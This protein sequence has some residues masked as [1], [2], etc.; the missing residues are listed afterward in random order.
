MIAAGTAGLGVL[1][2]F[3][4]WERVTSH[5]MLNLRFFRNRSFSAAVSSVWLVMFGLYGALF[6][7]TQYL[8]F[9][10]GYTPLQT[11]LRVLPAAAAVALV[12]PVSAVS[13]RLIGAKFTTAIG[14][15]IVTAGLWQ[16][17]GVSVTSTYADSVAGLA[18][19]G[20]G[21]G[22]TIPCTTAA[23]MGSVPR[24]DTGVGSA[25]N[26]TFMQ[27]GGALGVAVIGS[28]LATRY[29]GRMTGLLAP[30]HLP[31]GITSIIL[32]SVGGA[33]GAADRVG[34]TAGRLLA[35]AAQTSFISGMDLGLMTG[36]AVGLAGCLV[37]LVAMPSRPGR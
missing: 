15:L 33:L 1:A 34:G 35:H 11:G 2:G 22:L 24:G 7:L 6:V 28:L 31:H 26:G 5:P 36:A 9:L 13:V 17:S 3:A 32:G 14:L 4:A 37:A 10:L 29:T 27:V 19:L 25:T 8:Q 12:A 21:A 16:I 23:V 30:Y 18:M 20:I